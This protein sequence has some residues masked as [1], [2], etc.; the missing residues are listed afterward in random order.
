MKKS[1]SLLIALCFPFILLAQIMDTTTA[2]YENFDGSSVQTTTNY[3]PAFGGANGDWQ[4]CNTLY[5]SAPN[6][7][8]TP[9]YSSGGNSQMYT[10]A[11]PVTSTE[12]T[13]NRIYLAFDH[14][15]KVNQLDQTYIHYSLATGVDA[16]GNYIWGTWQALNFGTDTAWYYGDGAGHKATVSGGKFNHQSYSD[17]QSSN[18]AAVPTNAWW[19]HEYFDLT[20]K[21]LRT[22]GVTHVRFRFQDNKYSPT[23]SGTE[24]CAGWYVDNIQV[25]LSNC[26][27][28]LPK[29]TLTNPIYVNKNNNLLNNI[30]PYVINATISDNDTLNLN[31]LEFTYKVNNGASVTVPNTVL[32]NTRTGGRHQITAKWDLPTMCYFDT[33]RYHIAVKDVHGSDAV[34]IDTPMIAWHNQTNISNNNC[35][36]DSL[37]TF[38]HCFITGQAEPVTLYFKNKSDAT[39][40]QS[41]GSPYQTALNVTFKVE[42][43][44]HVV[45]HNSTHTWNGS[46][47]FDERDM[48]SLGQFTPTHGLNY[49][50]V[51]INSRNGQ[52]DGKH[53]KDTIKLV[54]YACDS[55]LHGNYTIGG[56]NP[57]FA[58][59]ADAKLA[60]SYCGINGPVTFHMRPG[61]YQD[62]DFRG[63]Y[64]GQS[65]TNTITF[66]GDNVNT[67]IVVNNHPDTNTNVYGAVTLINSN[68]TVSLSNF[69]FKNLTIQGNNTAVSRGV[70]IRGNSCTDI[71]FDG[72]HIS[73]NPTNT[74][75]NTSVVFGRTVAPTAQPDNVKLQNC[76]LTGGNYG[77]YYLGTSA[78]R[79]TLEIA[80]CT[81]NSCYRGIQTS[82]TNPNI[83]G[84]HISQY[85]MPTHQN[86]SGIYAE[87]TVGADVNGNIVDNTYD[88]EYGIFFKNATTQ[89][90]YIR[91][92]HVK[93]GNSNF[94]LYIE[95]CNSTAVD[96]GYIY[97]NE[98]ILYPVV[99]A[100]SYAVQIKSSNF[101]KVANNSFYV[102]SDAPYSNTAALRI[103]NNSKTY[104]NNNILMNYSNCSDNTNF[105]LYLNG[106]SSITGSYN[107]L[108]SASGVVAYY[109]VARNSVAEFQNAVTTATNTISVLPPMASPT[110]SLLPTS[111]TGLECGKNMDVNTDIRG[112]ARYDLTYMGA[113]ADQVALTDAAVTAMV[114]PAS[115][116]CPQGSYNITVT[117]A[118][119]GAS[120]LNFAQHHAVLKVI[121]SALNLN[122]SININSGTIPVLGT[123]TSS[124][125]ASNVVIPVNQNVDFTFIITTTGDNNTLNDTLV[126]NFVLETAIPDYEEDFSAGTQQTWTIQQL[127]GAG[128]WSFQ[129]G[130]GANPTIAPVYGTGRL[131]FNSKNF[132][133]NTESRAIMPVVNLAGKVNPILEVWFAHDNNSNKAAEGVTVKVSTNGGTTFTAINP[134]GASTS[135]LK[136]YQASATTPQWTL[137]TYDLSDYVANGCIYIAFDAKGQVGNNINIDRIRLRCLYNNDVAV[138]NVY[139][140]GE[141]PAQF[142]MQGVVSALV[143]NEGR[144]TQNNVK[145]YLNVTGATEQYHD[146]VTVASLASGAQTVVTFPNHAY[147]AQ[148]L[149]N[150][151]VRSRNDENNSNNAT[152]WRMMVTNNVVNYADTSAVGNMTGDYANIIRPCV[153]YKTSQELTVKAVKYY[154]DQ[155]YIANPEN[156]F[157]AFVSN[158]AG[159][160][161]AQSEVV[162][163]NTLQQGAWN[164]IPIQNYALTN[165]QN[166]YVGIEMLSNGDYLCSQVET[167]LRDSAFY[168]LNN[169][170]YVAQ[171]TGRFMIGAVVDTPFVH[172]IAILN[173]QNPTSRCDLGH[174]NIRIQITNNGSQNV[175]PGTVFKYSVN[176]QAAVSQTLTDTL[177]SHQTRFFTFNTAYDFTNN[178]INVDDNY[179]V[180]VWIVKDAQD[181]LQ[182]NDT[183]QLT[184]SSL[185]KADF[186]ILANDTVN[187]NYHTTGVLTA[188]LPSSI[189][190]GVLGWYAST[191]YETWNL[192][193]YGTSYTTPVIY[194]DTTFYVNANPGSIS[195]TTV[196]E[197]T[198]TGAQPF[199]FTSGYSRGRLLYLADEIGQRGMLTSVSVYVSTAATGQDG[200]P[201]KLYMKESSMTALPTA[202]AAVDWDLEKETA[203]LVY[204]GRIFFDQTG[205]YE[206]NLMTPFDFQEGN[207]I[208]MTETNCADYCTGTG[209]QC[210]NCGA[211]VSGT[212][213]Y[214][215]FRQTQVTGFC[216][217][218]NGNTTASLTGNYT[219]YNRRLNMKFNVADLDCGSQKVAVHVHVPDIP[220]YDVETQEL[221]YPVPGTAHCTMN[222]ENLQV[223]VKN[224]L[225]TAIPANKVVVHAR[226]NGT[227]I[228]QT[229]DEA[230]A[231]EEV[232]VVTFNT[233][234]DFTASTADITFNFVI[235]TTMNNEA[236]VYTGN[237]TIT[238]SLTST[239]TAHFQRDPITYNGNYTQ[240]YTIVEAADRPTGIGVTNYYF[241]DS[242][243]ATTPFYSTPNNAA[244]PTWTTPVLYD[245]VTYW[246]DCKT[247]GSNCYSNRVPVIVNVFHPQY[248]LITNSLTTPKDYQCGVTTSPQIQVNVGNTDTAATSTIPAG[249]F[250]LKANF[251]GSAN[252]TGNATVSSPISHLQNTDVAI[253][254]NNLGSTTQNR[255]YQYTIYSNPTNASMNVYRANDTI[256]GVL[257]VPANPV[258]PQNLTFTAPYGTAYT[259]VPTN[260]TL[261]YFYFYETASSTTPF[262]EGPNFTTDPIYGT[263]TYYYSGRI[264]DPDFMGVVE[265]GNATGTVNNAAPFYTTNGHSY[266]KI[267]YTK[268]ELGAAGR[269]D[270]ISVNVMTANTSGVAIPVKIWMKNANTEAENLTAGQV[271]WSNETNGAQLI[272]DGELAFNQVG[273]LSIPVPGGF[274]YTGEGIYMYTEH[275]CGGSSCLTGMGVGPEPKF[276]NSQYTTAAQKRTLQKY[277]N[278]ALTGSVA[279]SLINYR[280][281]TKFKFN[282]TCESPKSTITI[283]TSVPQHDVAVTA[284]VTPVQYASNRTAT[285]QVKVTIKNNGSTAASNFPV[286]Y[287]FNNNAPVTQNYTGSLA[288]GASA[289]LTFTTRVDL[290]SVYYCLPFKAYTGMSNDSYHGNDT[291]SIDIC[292]EDPCISRPASTYSTGAEISNVNFA[293]INNGTGTPYVNYTRPA[294]CDGLYT[295]Y[296][297]LTPGAIV[298]GQTYPLSVT[299]SF[300]TAT[301]TTVYKKVY[302]DYNR[303]G[304]FNDADE[305]VFTSA[306]V[307]YAAGGANATTTTSITIPTTAVTGLT[308]MRVICAAGSLTA[309]NSPCGTYNYNGETEDYAVEIQQPYGKDMG[310]FAYDHPVG[311]VC[312]D[313]NAKIRIVVKN[314]GTEAQT[315]SA[316]NALTLTTTVTGPNPATYT[317]TL[318]EGTIPVGGT[319]QL[320]MENVNLSTGGTYH[321]T[322]QLTYAGDLYASN[323][324]MSVNATVITNTA[325]TPTGFATV[326]FS[327]DF[328]QNNSEL[329]TWLPAGWFLENSNNNYKWKCYKGASPLSGNGYG[330]MHDN[331][332]ANNATFQNLAHYFCVSYGSNA[333][334]YAS[335][336]TALTTG[337]INLHYKNGYPVE[338]DFYKFI[339]GANDADFVMTVEAGS[340]N[341]YVAMDTLTKADGDQT[342]NTSPWTQ[343]VSTFND[344][345]EV[346]RI[347]FKVTGQHNRID[348]AIDDIGVN[349]GLPDLAVVSVDYPYAFTDTVDHP[350]NCLQIGDT[351]HPVLTLKNNGNSPISNFQVMC[352]IKAQGANEADTLLETVTD[353]LAPGDT[354]QYTFESGHEIVDSRWV[355]CYLYGII[356]YDKNNTNDMK[357]VIS[358]SNT[359]IEDYELTGMQLMQ[360][361][362]NPATGMTKIEYVLP[363]YGKA[364]LNIYSALGQLMYSDTQEGVEGSNFFEV[365]ASK[366]AD[367]VY[368]YTLTFK[369]II[370]TKKMVVQK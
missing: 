146:S 210:N 168:Y 291:L 336:Y 303:D 138:T 232:K 150:V 13:V 343:H 340:G 225:N 92:N 266:A 309:A 122:Q 201:V 252:A 89:D 90:F 235:Y 282:Y 129:E 47:C 109:T 11:I 188:T 48:L 84:S 274:D 273:W 355:E 290:T 170:S 108:V 58:T 307:P 192:L 178:Q 208:L 8:H 34:V 177:Y 314:L 128:N 281:N 1:L 182:Y 174:E 258:A 42:N 267:L 95:S 311:Q 10:A 33:I 123:I 144:Q 74:T 76:T 18:N 9:V 99:A 223:Q 215:M 72:C 278:T 248:D 27:L 7:Y 253:I 241:Y 289:D 308:R 171:T 15:C 265:A 356:D 354:M 270:T 149:K 224:L 275:D 206:I 179:N 124:V 147:N 52:V 80:N 25:I 347:R 211:Y 55:L 339:H 271:N 54:G 29:I 61:T 41:T 259:V 59:V 86:F 163:F 126:E 155:T 28:E 39:H 69:R 133:N 111:F 306:A 115:G 272:F 152:N 326:P 279:F 319:K 35:D 295:D 222:Q 240:T 165:M 199:V 360:N 164:T 102:K 190:Q 43:E 249:T 158:E 292:G 328:D 71:V 217:Y 202:A 351:L 45:T 131:F 64:I 106:T 231:P 110:D 195:E 359:G 157:R 209:T 36:L 221:V 32:T 226:I 245:T 286:S 161:V 312:P 88:A 330:P 191:G 66:Q 255:T 345:D 137:Y 358:C 24:V 305:C 156:G 85:N 237:D 127:V 205:W 264:E 4:I 141:T 369:D 276:Q 352:V 114:S 296:T 250:S 101:L 180:K 287:Q 288:A 145:V 297:N 96:T 151:E 228:T 60:L 323:D 283:N 46:L 322:T 256:S 160:I 37:N 105:P 370:L 363:E 337:C 118:N 203:T 93:V 227:E 334:T 103:E 142:G 346:G 189:N 75:V 94:G 361:V 366:L 310:I 236:V 341:Y 317:T 78:R 302:I 246:V 68:N 107:D 173:M 65:E 183:L 2:F 166:F 153:R 91:N 154:Y 125:I 344:Y 56:S 53:D 301:G 22:P 17:W 3:T 247:Q 5:K 298:K 139:A 175:M 83:H 26:E 280:W 135:L 338:V 81:I 63:N 79:N 51:Y 130:T 229:V 67:V 304:D 148:E 332:Y 349:F 243:T 299:H 204:D 242:E 212:T 318:D 87:Y 268:S 331:T 16:D 198:L 20:N 44:N 12:M 218:K 31:T 100:N 97:N 315:F 200:I 121:S 238:A 50:T 214:P 313:T 159:E 207:L 112:V 350:N 49:I 120:V 167:P 213:G 294:G 187:V 353:V 254:V 132:A 14:I 284:I 197:G 335:H 73:A 368:Y 184:I 196:G 261:D 116:E 348:P 134:E 277:Q 162:H 6:S 40:S 324:T 82:Y 325:N 185:G 300:E 193:G 230:F 321:L 113:Y 320:V 233:P 220:T 176:G 365:N 357:R 260:N 329:E 269:I 70:V 293:G 333:T 244:N 143:R 23:S 285:E 172:D 263:S 119:K 219:A 251:T 186:P 136:R 104:A 239:R 19:K 30:G 38:P 98:V 362:P 169:G 234:F 77:V 216:Q 57:D 194:F 117:L 316:D 367:G 257:H 364:S 140:Q 181:R 62:M 327:E 262:A 342:S 21:I